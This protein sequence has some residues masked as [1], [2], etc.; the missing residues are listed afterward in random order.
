LWGND[1]ND[2][3]IGGKNFDTIYGGSGDD[4]LDAGE[5]SV[6]FLYGQGGRDWFYLWRVSPGDHQL[7][8]GGPG[9]DTLDL[10]NVKVPS[11]GTRGVS[12]QL[13]APAPNMYPV[14]CWATP[15]GG[16]NCAVTL[17]GLSSAAGIEVIYG[18][19]GG[20][21]LVGGAGNNHFA[22]QAGDD[23]LD[24][25]GGNDLLEGNGDDDDLDGGD[26]DDYLDGGSG[27]DMATGSGGWDT[28]YLV[29]FSPDLCESYDYSP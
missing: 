6:N 29:E 19:P 16:F 18:S 7:V 23:S 8:S 3:L 10:R 24:G 28:C 2:T 5:W 9:R 13:G 17:E 1:G 11:G 25:G 21:L 26:G 14:D 27:W 22:G 15:P 12:V 4:I 20:D